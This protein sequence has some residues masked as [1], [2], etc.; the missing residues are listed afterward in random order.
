[1][2]ITPTALLAT[3]RLNLLRRPLMHACA[4]EECL[5]V[6]RLKLAALIEAGELPWAWDFGTGHARK[7]VRLLAACVVE[8]ASGPIPAIGATRNLR[9]PEVLAL[10]LPEK[11]ETLRSAELQRLFHAGRDLIHDL[12]EAG[13][14]KRVSEK[15]PATGPNASPRF[16]RASVVRLLE[17]RRI[18]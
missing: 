3:I 6:S 17:Q 13:E 1:L 2:N 10:I 9:L 18:A 12:H 15:L 16:T 11:R 14:I 8:R 7:E 5:D 4:A